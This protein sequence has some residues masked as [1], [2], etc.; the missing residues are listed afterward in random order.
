V[1]RKTKR[2]QPAEPFELKRIHIIGGALVLLCSAVI[3]VVLVTLLG[4]ASLSE[5]EPELL[6]PPPLLGP[7]VREPSEAGDLLATKTWDEMTDDERQLVRS[8]IIRA[9]DDAEFRAVSS[10]VIGI[11]VYRR[12]GTTWASRQYN[13]IESPGG[14]VVLRESLIF[15]CGAPQERVRAVRYNTTPLGTEVLEAPGEIGQRAWQPIIEPIDWSSVRDLGFEEVDGRRTHVFQAAFIGG[16]SDSPR[17]QYWIDVETAQ[18]LRWAELSADASLSEVSD[19][20][21]DWGKLKPALVPD[22][23]AV[24]DC[25]ES[26]QSVLAEN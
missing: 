8:E 24:P 4:G 2:Q 11:D 22:G 25:V 20:T 6:R 7:P 26:I 1:S 12:D 19:Y 15:Y 3:A 23:Q 9:Y 13:N 21:L 10:R 17:A 16:P 14:A 5:D 18:L